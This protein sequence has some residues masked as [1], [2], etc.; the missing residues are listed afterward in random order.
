LEAGLRSFFEVKIRRIAEPVLG[1]TRGA[2]DG[3]IWSFIPFL[4]NFFTFV[5]NS[6]IISRKSSVI[7]NHYAQESF[8]RFV[9]VYIKT[10]VSCAGGLIAGVS[11]VH[12]DY[13]NAG[14]LWRRL[15]GGYSEGSVWK[16]ESVIPGAYKELV[17]AWKKAENK[18][19]TLPEEIRK[20]MRLNFFWEKAEEK[21]IKEKPLFFE[22]QRNDFS[23]YVCS[24]ETGYFQRLY[25]LIRAHPDVNKA[26]VKDCLNELFVSND[27]VG[28]AVRRCTYI[29]SCE[30]FWVRV[31]GDDVV[32]ALVNELGND[33]GCPSLLMRFCLYPVVYHDFRSEYL[34][35][36]HWVFGLSGGS[37][38]V[39]CPL[40]TDVLQEN[41]LMDRFVI[42]MEIIQYHREKEV[43]NGKF[44]RMPNNDKEWVKTTRNTAD[45]QV[46]LR[47]FFNMRTEEIEKVEICDKFIVNKP[48]SY[49]P[50][51]MVLF[52]KIEKKQGK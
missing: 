6:A 37:C 52:E 42:D 26:Y 20:K 24:W 30:A 5:S 50:N 44:V 7:T 29:I 51:G 46:C 25:S 1:A 28:K 45:F 13:P 15:S 43:Q 39:F 35:E 41:G 16:S 11:S 9:G 33:T 19:G 14:K 4:G 49:F 10:I 22:G 38:D 8:M 23:F 34:K 48:L 17:T 36:K 40:L 27:S 2:S 32:N 18:D 12:A 31:L 21:K 3:R 47:L